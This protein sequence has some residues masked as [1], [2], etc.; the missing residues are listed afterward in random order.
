MRNLLFLIAT[1]CVVNINAQNYLITFDGRG[2]S[3]IVTTVNIENLAAGTSISLNGNETLRLTITTDV[4]TTENNVSENIKVFPNPMMG[5]SILQIYPPVSGDAVISVFDL[6]GKNVAQIQSYLDNSLQ[7]FRL[8]GLS[9]GYHIIS[10]KGSN[11]QLSGKL[12]SNSRVNGTASI[13]KLTSNI[14]LENNK[15]TN[16]DSKGEPVI[17]D[18]EYTDG[19][20]LKFTGKSGDYSM[21]LTDI[22]SGDK[23]I[24]FD[25]IACTDGDNNNYPLVEIGTQVW[26]A[27]NLQTTHYNDNTAIPLVEGSTEWSGLASPAYCL[28]NNEETNKDT[29]GALYNWYTVNTGKICPAGWHVPSH[30]EWTTLEN[31]LIS[32]AYNYDGTI[33]DN[34]IAKSLASTTIWGASSISGAVGNTDYPEKRNIT[35]F[36]APPGGL[37]SIGGDFFFLGNTGFLWSTSLYTPDYARHRSI[38]NNDSFVSSTLSQKRVG[39]SVRCIKD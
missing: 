24:T 3:T 10:V 32:N 7:E 38:N 16:V 1:F 26:M 5:S 21:V 23:I 31:Y 25:F 8:S 11:Y 36:T 39:C 9:S 14:C 4:N 37:R 2:E 29:Y 34:K 35:G 22:P 20:R 28:C 17:I 15:V 18:M 19:D 12:L 33:T 13:K 30:E 27:E 6:T